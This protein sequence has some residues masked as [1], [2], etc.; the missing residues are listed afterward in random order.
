MTQLIELLARYRTAGSLEEKNE[1]AVDFVQLFGPN[2]HLFLAQRIRPEVVD[3]VFQETLK[4]IFR[5]EHQFEGASDAQFWGWCY[6]IARNKLVDQVRERD[7]RV[8]R[9]HG[10]KQ[11]R[12][13]SRRWMGR[14]H[15]FGESERPGA[16][17]GTDGQVAGGLLAA[18]RVPGVNIHYR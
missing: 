9:H 12:L 17:D 16:A 13:S 6:Q 11:R 7:G 14:L 10:G 3:D 18:S 2:L 1:A 5:N 15:G 4:G 8:A